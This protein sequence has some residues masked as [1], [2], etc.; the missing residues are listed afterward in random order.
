MLAPQSL[1]SFS[2]EQL[3]KKGWSQGRYTIC[4]LDLGSVYKKHQKTPI[5]LS[6]HQLLWGKKTILTTNFGGKNRSREPVKIR[7]EAS[8]GTDLSF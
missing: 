4:Q 8:N 2:S 7:S 5:S 3:G 1:I 6:G